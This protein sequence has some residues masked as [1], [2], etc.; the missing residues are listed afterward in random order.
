M[1]RLQTAVLGITLAALLLGSTGPRAESSEIPVTALSSSLNMDP[2]LVDSP[3]LVFVFPEMA[4]DHPAQA[5]GT[6]DVY[7]YDQQ[8]GLGVIARPGQH[9]LFALSQPVSWRVAGYGSTRETSRL[10]AGWSV[11]S[12]AWRLG[13]ALRGSQLREENGRTEQ[14]DYYDPP[15]LTGRAF[16]ERITRLEAALGAGLRSRSVD[17]DLSLEL[18]RHDQ[19][20]SRASFTT[21]AQYSDTTAL[22]IETNGDLSPAFSARARFEIGADAA[23][24]VATEWSEFRARWDGWSYRAMHDDAD[25]EWELVRLSP[26]QYGRRWF[27]GAAVL[28]PTR[29]VD[30]IDVSASFFDVDQPY[31][32]ADESYAWNIHEGLRTGAVAV[33]V[34]EEL[35]RNLEALA[36]LRVSYSERRTSEEMRNSTR[37]ST[38]ILK[39]DEMNENLSAGLAYSWRRFRLAGMLD[40]PPQLS[41]PFF[42]ADVRVL[43]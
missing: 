43:F 11:R 9:A 31:I 20:I 3:A 37:T 32:A 27:A 30:E 12:G 34:R 1:H 36:G 40:M 41:R 18:R 28:V 42:I 33:S 4:A 35:L 23:I 38:D 17:L 5:M 25:E 13:A 14:D 16:Q 39:R 29:V 2:I 7:D 6:V 24:V 26:E 15:R 21:T 10:Q 19:T 8:N 22:G